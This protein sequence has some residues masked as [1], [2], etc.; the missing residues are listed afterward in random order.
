MVESKNW[1]KKK[2]KK[3]AGQRTRKNRDTTSS[4][5]NRRDKPRPEPFSGATKRGRKN[6]KQKRKNRPTLR[7]RQKTYAGEQDLGE[8]KNTCEKQQKQEKNRNP[9]SLNGEAYF[10]VLQK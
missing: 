8:K 9:K 3:R 10:Y 6:E 1:K 7:V 5:K 4:N 2:T